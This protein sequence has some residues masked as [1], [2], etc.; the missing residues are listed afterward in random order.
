[1]MVVLQ[2]AYQETIQDEADE[3]LMYNYNPT[4]TSSSSSEENALG[5]TFSIGLKISLRPGK[6]G[7]G[8]QIKLTYLDQSSK[9]LLGRAHGSTVK[10]GFS[11]SGEIHDMRSAI[12]EGVDSALSV[13]PLKGYPITDVEVRFR[14]DVTLSIYFSYSKWYY[15]GPYSKSI[16]DF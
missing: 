7:S 2:V 12:R 15:Y 8:R 1:M 14:G 3:F 5:E 13:G 6:N 11:N 9:V 4:Q 16:V 10:S